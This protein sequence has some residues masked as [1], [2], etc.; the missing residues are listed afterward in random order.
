MAER[1]A[2]INH[3]RALLLERGIVVAQGRHKLEVALS[4]S[5]DE[6]D[7]RLSPRMRVLVEDLRAE[8]RSLDE[9]IA[10][11]GR[12]VRAYGR[13]RMKRRAGF[14]RYLDR[15]HQRDRAC[16]CGRRRRGASGAAVTLPPGW[17]L[18]PPTGDNRR[19]AATARNIQARQPL[20][21]E[22]T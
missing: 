20:I 22:R 17:G 2:L 16:C 9:R 21:C 7:P 19:Q 13:A 3:L 14:Q 11:F 1:T 6:D 8:W 18:S 12:G 10:A 15:R 4:V 5:A